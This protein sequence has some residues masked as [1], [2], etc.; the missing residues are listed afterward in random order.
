MTDIRL[1]NR[2]DTAGIGVI[3]PG[4]GPYINLTPVLVPRTGGRN[5]KVRFHKNK[6]HIV[7]RLINRLMVPGHRGKKHRLTSGRCTGKGQQVYKIVENC[8]D[9]IEKTM[10]K[11]PVEVLVR[12]IENAAPRDEITSIEYGGAVY[13]QAVDCSPHRRVDIALKIMIQGSYN[14]SY[15]GNKKIEQY[16]ADEIINAYNFDNRSSAIAKKLELERQ[17]DSSR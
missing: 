16:L 6:Y 2:W 5:V 17:A 14:K 4:L 15:N 1:F 11:N 9:I 12:A 10:N 7:E 3:D 13:P 8:L